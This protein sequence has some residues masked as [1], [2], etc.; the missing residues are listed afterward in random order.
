[1]SELRHRLRATRSRSTR[2]PASSAPPSR[3][4]PGWSTERRCAPSTRSGS[5]RRH[6][7]GAARSPAWPAS[8]TRSTGSATGTAS[9]G[10]AASCSTSSSCRSAPRTSCARSF[11]RIAAAARRRRLAV[12]KRFGPANPAPMSFPHPGLDARPRPARHRLRWA[13]CSTTSTN[14]SLA[15]GGRVYLAKDSRARPEVIA[16]MYP[17]L[18]EFA[19]ARDGS[20]PSAASRPTWPAACTFDRT[21]D[22][23]GSRHDRRPRITPVR[24][25][26]RRH[27]RHRRGHRERWAATARRARRRGGPARSGARRDGGDASIARRRS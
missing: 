19:K 5:A 25:P 4:R 21:R 27:Q 7:G 9:T 12:L 14:S 26:A 10:A 1:M 3:C 16:A 18:A 23:L 15:A 11:D 6:G 8:S 20:T 22:Q 24:A 17:R 13:R 2:S